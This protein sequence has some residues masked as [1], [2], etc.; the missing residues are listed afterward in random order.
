MSTS[1]DGLEKRSS[2]Y[3]A[4]VN[5]HTSFVSIPCQGFVHHVFLSYLID[6]ANISTDDI[7]RLVGHVKLALYL[8]VHRGRVNCCK[9]CSL[10]D[11]IRLD[12]ASF[13]GLPLSCV[14][15]VKVLVSFPVWLVLLSPSL[16][17]HSFYRPLCS[18]TS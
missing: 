4:A 14:Q 9:T 6:V 17:S 7:Y 12:I 13:F 5:R 11:T 15:V 3:T 10:W 16:P 2:R 18:V 1:D 8:S